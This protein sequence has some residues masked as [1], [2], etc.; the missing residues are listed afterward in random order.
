MQE[1][2]F[3]LCTFAV[4]AQSFF[5][6]YHVSEERDLP[7]MTEFAAR[8][9]HVVGP[10]KSEELAGFFGLDSHHAR[11]LIALLESESLI[12]RSG[13][14]IQLSEYATSRFAASE[15]GSLRL[16]K[17]QERRKKV[18]FDLL[19]YSYLPREFGH[20][21]AGFCVGLRLPDTFVLSETK[22]RAEKAFFKN[23]AEVNRT[24]EGRRALALYKVDGVEGQ[25]R[26]SLPVQQQFF[27]TAEG[28][29]DR[30]F[31]AGASMPEELEQV[32]SPLV[33]DTL[34]NTVVRLP[35]VANDFVAVFDDA[36]MA[37]FAEKRGGLNLGQYLVE[38]HSNKSVSYGDS[39]TRPV[40][41]P[42]YLPERT[43]DF[44]SALDSAKSATRTAST[45]EVLWVIPDYEL[46]GRT[47]AVRDAAEQ[48]VTRLSQNN[49][50]AAYS[51]S[52]ICRDARDVRNWVGQLYEAGVTQPQAVNYSDL[53]RRCEVVVVPEVAA[54][55]VYWC[56]VSN[57]DSLLAPVGFVT[58]STTRVRR[59][60]EWVE[61]LR[62]VSKRLA[63][64]S[65]SPRDDATTPK[66]KSTALLGS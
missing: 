36:V 13:E 11:E 35:N 26:L 43:A 38:V 44:L 59:V 53:A 39:M 63:N 18:I 62:G 61:Q 52:W 65:A 25:R 41:G 54:Y 48:F 4:P 14:R 20:L 5:F 45:R 30:R 6:R 60:T 31:D 2:R 19:T 1:F 33:S 66:G 3:N 23:F 7:I 49:E 24:S 34:A 37:R 46:W 12:Q 28:Q 27:V 10:M 64:Q 51:V 55:V 42:A 17:M 57:S 16:T 9:L 29:A 21:P 40:V 50:D 15:S 22:E 47:A 58:T 32:L 8:L 56:N